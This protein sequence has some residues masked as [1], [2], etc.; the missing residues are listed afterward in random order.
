MFR[1][2]QVL[3]HHPLF[4][5]HLIAQ[6]VDEHDREWFAGCKLNHLQALPGYLY[7]LLR[8][9]LMVWLGGVWA[10][11]YVAA[12]ALVTAGL[13]GGMLAI[14]RARLNRQATVALW[15]RY[16]AC[17]AVV[18]GVLSGVAV[19]CAP[20]QRL[21]LVV[22]AITMTYG[23]EAYAQFPLPRM[24]V[25]AQL[26]GVGAMTIGL[27]VRP[28]ALPVPA[29]VLFALQG[30]SAHVRIFNF[31]YLFATRRLRTRKLTHANETIQLLLNQYD[32]HGSDC[33][34]ETDAA[35]V[36][37]GASERLCGMAGLAPAQINGRKL[38]DLYEPGVE[39]DAIR[40]ACHRLKPFR[41]LVAPVM[42]PQGQ[43]WWLLSGCA[44][45][46]S[47]GHHAGFRGFIRDVTDRH[48]AET[49][50][51]FLANHDAL[52]QIAN[53]AEFHARLAVALRDHQA[54][55]QTAAE[56][57]A[58]SG[59]A[60]AFAVM[61]IDL[62]RFKLINDSHGHAAGD[63]VLV[64]CATRL[65]QLI[66]ANGMVARL[67]GDE[68]A[69][70]LH[71]PQSVDAVVAVA[72]AAI[73]TLS[74]PIRLDARIVH[75]G[76]SIGVALAGLHG[77]SGDELLRAADMAQYDAKSSGRG[78]AV[79]Y[80]ADMLRSLADRQ[81]MEI[82]L[83]LALAVGEFEL[84]YQPF[85]AL[86]S[87][88]IVGF[89]ALIRWNHPQRGLIEPA[90]FIPLAEASGL[91][92]PIGE[93]VLR[94]ALAE[95]ATWPTD[96]I[97]AVNVS[98]M[99][100]RGGEILRQMVAALSTSG[101]D[102]AR[103]EL[104]ITETVLIENEVQCLAVLHRLRKLGVRI[105]LD[106][107]GTG[108][109]SLNYLRSF[110]FDKIKI[111][112]CFVSD[113]SLDGDAGDHGDSAAIVEAVLDLAAK[114]NMETIAEGVEHESQRERLRASGCDQVQG[115]L[116]GRAMPA[117]DLPIARIGARAAT[118]RTDDH[119]YTVLADAVGI[120]SGAT[121]DTLDQRAVRR[122]AVP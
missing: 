83:R 81:A 61:F 13:I 45:F 75:V 24:A 72:E 90:Q 115:W 18:I 14:G 4:L 33:L 11:W 119:A 32:E 3:S 68:F 80:S 47:G 5:G 99:Q 12:N 63:V 107:F 122:R 15:L 62:D 111:D 60:I 96:L 42:T 59:G 54:A 97:V 91:I 66:G 85:V 114:L 53:R 6:D 109:S 78:C 41:D 44:V 8:A 104:E 30:L 87:G 113:L 71:A 94:E 50:V 56:T 64:E 100:L 1:L 117:A 40:H 88:A 10:G 120:S 98:A 51:R 79:V 92:L 55:A 2:R 38:L 102:P 29:L 20:D 7:E 48:H 26:L 73:A 49:R 89:E 103:L 39:I 76:A 77:N 74:A 23:V 52:T 110:P 17:R 22:I 65:S 21:A 86:A 118:P 57:S 19:A 37:R 28:G 93:W 58:D 82:E 36:V 106:D 25:M 95:A 31:Y 116:T 9:G 16:M 108:Y 84:Y 121:A 34:V 67:G 112:R 46:D 43:R 101:F 105:A 70:L 35:G 69:V 27:L